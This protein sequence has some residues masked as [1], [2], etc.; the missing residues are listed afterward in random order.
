MTPVA[1]NR[2]EY[3]D[4]QLDQKRKEKNKLKLNGF[5][6]KIRLCDLQNIPIRGHNDSGCILVLTP[7]EN[8]GNFQSFVRYQIGGG[9]LFLKNHI[10]NSAENVMYTSPRIQNALIDSLRNIIQ[11]KII[12]DVKESEYFTILANE[13]TDIS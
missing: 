4:K 7:S 13:I 1:E 8:N 9:D 12:G 3:V 10:E 6:D 2:A 11:N 5:V